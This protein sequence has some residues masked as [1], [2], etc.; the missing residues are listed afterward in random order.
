MDRVIKFRGFSKEKNKW[1]VGHLVSKP[2]CIV[3]E[4]FRFPVECFPVEPES[5][6]QFT[7]LLDKQ[8]IEIYEGDILREDDE[9]RLEVVE[10]DRYCA[11]FTPF[12]D[13]CRDFLVGHSE[14]IGNIY[15][16]PDLLKQEKQNG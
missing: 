13:S 14:V 4:I 12:G 2:P 3:E 15:E 16:T 10:W 1:C 8:G 7:G 5:V 9:P 11:G 6:G